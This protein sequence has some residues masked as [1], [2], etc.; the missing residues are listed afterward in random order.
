MYLCTSARSGESTVSDSFRPPAGTSV[1]DFIR[2][3]SGQI[4]VEFNTEQFGV[5]QRMLNYRLA[6][7]G[8]N[9][10]FS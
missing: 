9:Q 7:T 2:T 4:S 6:T 10:Q 8:V 3:P 5:S 1:Q